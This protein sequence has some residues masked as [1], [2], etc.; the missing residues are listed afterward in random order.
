M[1]FAWN[2]LWCLGALFTFAIIFH[3]GYNQTKVV[4]DCIWK[5]HWTKVMDLGGGIFVCVGGEVETNKSEHLWNNLKSPMS[6][7]SNTSICLMAKTLVL[8]VAV[9]W[10]E[11]YSFLH[12]HSGCSSC[13]FPFGSI[14]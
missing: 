14:F 3:L 9:A 6:D 8:E 12:M 7:I 13:I 11:I 1:E 4:D 5:L 10:Y 2:L